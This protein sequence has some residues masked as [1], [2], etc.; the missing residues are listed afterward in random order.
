MFL[1]LIIA[2]L[3][4]A[5]TIVAGAILAD[6]AIKAHGAWCSLA[7]ER[8]LYRAVTSAAL[9]V[10]SVR[11]ARPKAAPSLSH[12]KLSGRTAFALAA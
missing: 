5:V 2:A 4:A 12:R 8:A 11:E 6:S 1:S 3:F 7:R 9:P 10:Q